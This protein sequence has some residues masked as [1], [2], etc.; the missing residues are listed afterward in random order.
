MKF[1]QAR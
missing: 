1:H